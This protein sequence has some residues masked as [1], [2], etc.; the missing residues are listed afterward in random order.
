M[1]SAMTNIDVPTYRRIADDV[2]RRVETGEWPPGTRIPAEVD[3]QA[4]YGCAR[5]TVRRAIFLLR[6]EGLVQARPLGQF[7]RRRPEKNVLQ[8]RVGDR[9]TARMP[10]PDERAERDMP[11]DTPVLVVTEVDGEIGVY[12]ADVTEVLIPLPRRNPLDG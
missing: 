10:T 5:A 3:L 12:P 7:V 9:V 4:E 2:R 6:D 1:V 8:G 11:E